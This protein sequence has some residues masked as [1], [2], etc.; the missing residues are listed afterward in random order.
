MKTRTIILVALVAALAVGAFALRDTLFG[1]DDGVAIKGVPVRRGP[2]EISVL[3]T[4][5][6][7]AA[8]SISLRSEIEGRSTILYLIDE[9]ELV[10]EGTLLCELDTTSMVDERINQEINVRNAESARIKSEKALEIQKSQNESDLASAERQ[11]EFAR[12]DLEKYVGVMGT[13]DGGVATGPADEPAKGP[14][15]DQ[16][17]ASELAEL[18]ALGERGQ[19]INDRENE[20]LVADE[21]LKRAQDKLKW[22]EEL[23]VDGFLTRTELEADRLAEKRAVIRL[24]QTKRALELFLAY[25][26]PRQV[27][28]L[29]A[30]VV[31]AERELERVKLQNDA[32]LVD[33]E[34]DLES[35]IRKYELEVEKF[36]KLEDQ[37]GKAK[38]YAPVAGMVVYA[39]EQG[40][41]WSGG[42][43]VAEGK[44]VRE[45]QEIITI[46]SAGDMLVEASV[47]ESV[48]EQVRVG[49]NVK[50]TV[51]ALP[52]REFNGIVKFKAVLP[53]QN[54]FWAN[55]DLRV[56][57][58]EISVTD[59]D[60]AMR[61]G[62]TCAIRVLVENVA[63]CIYIP[64]Q[65]RFFR[66]EQAVVFVRDEGGIELRDVELGVYNE[67]W[68]QVK[69]GLEE[70]EIVLM[71]AP[72]GFDLSD[73]PPPPKSL[74]PDGP[75]G[76]AEGGPDRS[77]PG[78][79]SQ[80]FGQGGASEGAGPGAGAFRGPS[81]GT[82]PEGFD[83]SR[84]RPGGRRGGRG[85]GGDG[86]GAPSSG[87]PGASDGG[88][89][90]APSD[91]GARVDGAAGAAPSGESAETPK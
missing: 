49:Q 65:A 29:E 10:Q 83:P 37:L 45:R 24:E 86:A 25:D 63:D 67:S 13:E 55:P 66:G 3:E 52:E 90:A 16:D 46:P 79:G 56:Y 69:S 58:T 4:G 68:I 82:P 20:V 78:A 51:D 30:D 53:D 14:S 61:P 11:L 76:T 27:K 38:I 32:R 31:E 5:N 7:K 81:G 47:H 26:D 33:Y 91:A 80:G 1:S 18:T 89:G 48:L 74:E 71:S 12:L 88:S 42:E 39:K 15:A 57:R 17:E 41:R 40:N 28:S 22:S 35:K 2:L 43:P 73:A 6:L 54:S 62:M 50:I 19:E 77:T 59:A 70:G 87:A 84:M 72:P 44:E 85:P 23:F 8:K 75:P 36:K 21:E 60:P 34:A 9:G 64:L